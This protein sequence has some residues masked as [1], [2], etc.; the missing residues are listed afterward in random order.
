MLFI[1]KPEIITKKRGIISNG[2]NKKPLLELS[3][4]GKNPLL[5]DKEILLNINY[6]LTN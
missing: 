6:L 4:F 5:F 3:F 1:N 2:E